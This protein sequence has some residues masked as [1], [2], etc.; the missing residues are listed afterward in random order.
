MTTDCKKKYSANDQDIFA[1]K[2]LDGNYLKNIHAFANWA[3]GRSIN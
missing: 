2:K 1:L 3:T